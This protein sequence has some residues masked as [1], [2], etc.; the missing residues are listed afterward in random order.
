MNT[1]RHPL[2]PTQCMHILPY[3]SLPTT[4]KPTSGKAV[5]FWAVDRIGRDHEVDADTM[6]EMEMTTLTIS[7]ATVIPVRFGGLSSGHHQRRITV[8]VLINKGTIQKGQRLFWV[9][10]TVTK[11]Q[12]KEKAVRASR[13]TLS[14]MSDGGGSKKQK[15]SHGSDLV[16]PESFA[17]S[18]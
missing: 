17:M 1:T 8:P 15:L 18:T 6:A 7:S 2:K 9:D 14:S 11:P 5:P 4:T 10:E 12:P 16:G 13:A 3:F